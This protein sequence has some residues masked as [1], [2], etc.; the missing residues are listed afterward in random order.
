MYMLCYKHVQNV[1]LLTI[2]HT[3]YGY[4]SERSQKIRHVTTVTYVVLHSHYESRRCGPEIFSSR[5]IGG[6][7][8]KI[9]TTAMKLVVEIIKGYQDFDRMVIEVM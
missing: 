8:T 9:L 1:S 7:C 3:T 4:T 5:V 2:F 6:N